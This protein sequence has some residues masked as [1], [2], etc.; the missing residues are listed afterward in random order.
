LW[1]AWW[2]FFSLYKIGISSSLCCLKII[3]KKKK[4]TLFFIVSQYRNEYSWPHIGILTHPCPLLH[5]KEERIQNKIHWSPKIQSI[6]VHQVTKAISLAS[7]KNSN[8][9][10]PFSTTLLEYDNFK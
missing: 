3:I 6:I 7:I 1:L 10:S 5:T 8:F 9:L 2:D 4:K